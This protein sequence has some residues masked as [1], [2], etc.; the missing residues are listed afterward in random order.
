MLAPLCSEISLLPS[1]LIDPTMIQ[2]VTMD[3]GNVPTSTD[4]YVQACAPQVSSGVLDKS[5]LLL[6]ALICW[7]R[8]MIPLWI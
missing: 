4:S 7:L 3:T 8:I 5:L 6:M 1:S 2:G